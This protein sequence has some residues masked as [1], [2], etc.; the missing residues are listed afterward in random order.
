MGT[1]ASQWAPQ[2]TL[3][4]GKEGRLEGWG[5]CGGPW[6]PDR[7]WESPGGAEGA[8]LNSGTMQSDLLVS[9]I[10]KG[11]EES[12]SHVEDG[13]EESTSAELQGEA[14]KL[15]SCQTMRI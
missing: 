14:V 8:R 6:R 5:P 13:L 2:G 1:T 3:G 9:K 15:S 4:R 12:S 7:G 10:L 11:Q